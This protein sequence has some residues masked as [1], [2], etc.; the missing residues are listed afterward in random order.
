VK[1]RGYE[2]GHPPYSARKA[3]GNDLREA[4]PLREE[5]R[6]RAGP[7]RELGGGDRGGLIPSLFQVS[8]TP[9][10]KRHHDRRILR[11]LQMRAARRE[12]SG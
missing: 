11:T 4:I 7:L 12:A 8:R 10:L 1:G 5:K 9:G 2:S 3:R 6:E